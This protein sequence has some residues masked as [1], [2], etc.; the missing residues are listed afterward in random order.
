MISYHSFIKMCNRYLHTSFTDCGGRGIINF[1]RINN[2][3]ISCS[4]YMRKSGACGKRAHCRKIEC[5]KRRVHKT[6]LPKRKRII[7]KSSHK[8]I[9]TAWCADCE[10]KSAQFFSRSVQKTHNIPYTRMQFE[11]RLWSWRTVLLNDA[12]LLWLPTH[13]M[14]MT[15]FELTLKGKWY[16]IFLRCSYYCIDLQS[17]FTTTIKIS[18]HLDSSI[19]SSMISHNIYEVFTDC[20]QSQ[21]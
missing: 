13:I 19:Y 18:S 11:D 21:S 2:L 9:F 5:D 15:R 6:S 1:E 4:N 16:N 17:F 10:W 12:L 20:E 8:T 14:I 3:A 7:T